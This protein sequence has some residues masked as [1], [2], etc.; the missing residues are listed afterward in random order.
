MEDNTLGTGQNEQLDGGPNGRSADVTRPDDNRNVSW[1]VPDPTPGDDFVGPSPADHTRVN[2][3]VASEPVKSSPSKG[4]AIHW[5]AATAGVAAGLALVTGL[6]VGAGAVYL[7]DDDPG[8]TQ[9][10]S[11]DVATATGA[12]SDQL[13]PTQVAAQIPITPGAQP[14]QQATAASTD[15]GFGAGP[16]GQ[17]PTNPQGTSDQ[18]DGFQPGGMPPMPGG[19]TGGGPS[20][21]QTGGS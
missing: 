1:W 12:Q 7:A 16:G 14:D 15:G 2:P 21:S 10:V 17:V 9:A 13:D 19:Q 3:A 20:H 8:S 4:P 6:T 5:T 18:P 11:T